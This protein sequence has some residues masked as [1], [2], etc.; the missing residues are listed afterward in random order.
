[1]LSIL[2]THPAT[3]PPLLQAKQH[4]YRH[5]Q[6]LALDTAYEIF[7]HGGGSANSRPPTDLPAGANPLLMPG[8]NVLTSTD[9]GITL[10]PPPPLITSPLTIPSTSQQQPQAGPLTILGTTPASAAVAGGASNHP[11]TPTTATGGAGGTTTV[12]G[13]SLEAGIVLSGL[14]PLTFSS[15]G[16]PSHPLPQP[17]PRTS[18]A[19]AS[20]TPTGIGLGLAGPLNLLDTNTPGLVALPTQAVMT[21]GGL[22]SNNHNHNSNHNG[23]TAGGSTGQALSLLTPVPAQQQGTTTVGLT[24]TTTTTI[25]TAPALL[26]NAGLS[27][28]LPPLTSLAVPA[29]GS[30]FG[31]GSNGPGT[32]KRDSAGHLGH[33][34]QQQQ[35]QEGGLGRLSAGSATG[36]NGGL[37]GLHAEG[38]EAGEQQVI[39]RQALVSCR[40][41]TCLFYLITSLLCFTVVR[42]SLVISRHTPM[43]ASCIPAPPL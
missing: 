21:R 34:Q 36:G 1:M 10:A 24:T 37:N 6:R 28:N 33:G 39:K 29:S 35:R 5:R 19:H 2:Y 25:A 26:A 20:G 12:V 27:P 43:N 11:P 18:R 15:L 8:S 17:S 41:P 7:L 9:L 30:V 42:W 22:S 16:P 4:Y 32:A 14:P 38:P 3:A 40:G 31:A 13:A 23:T